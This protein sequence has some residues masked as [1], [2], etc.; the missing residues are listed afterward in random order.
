MPSRLRD[1]RVIAA[2]GGIVYAAVVFAWLRANGVYWATDDV[3]A[4]AFGVGYALVGLFLIGAV[5][6]YLLV[7]LSLVTPAA[8]T[9][10]LLGKTVHQWAYGTHLHPLSSY[11]VVWPLLLGFALVPGLAEALV[12]YGTD[13]F[14]DRGGLG[15]LV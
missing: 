9:L 3:A 1:P 10:W 12:R 6:L 2:V 13:R 4:T 14:V 5:P 7:R 15:P 8:A 11:L